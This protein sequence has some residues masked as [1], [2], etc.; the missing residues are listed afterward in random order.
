LMGAPVLIAAMVYQLP[1]LIKSGALQDASM[2]AAFGISIV[3]TYAAIR[4]LMHFIA[5]RSYV[6]F[7][8]YRGALGMMILLL[9]M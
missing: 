1:V 5:H 4:F 2:W 9:M 3:S 8:L 7:V 6:W